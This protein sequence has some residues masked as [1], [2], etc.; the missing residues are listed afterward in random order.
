MK[1][2]NPKNSFGFLQQFSWSLQSSEIWFHVT[3]S[4]YFEK[5]Q[6]FFLKHFDPYKSEHNVVPKLQEPN[7]QWQGITS[8]KIK[9]L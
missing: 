3:G 1:Q 2:W 6:L 8:Q 9:D 5:M 7:I 4:W